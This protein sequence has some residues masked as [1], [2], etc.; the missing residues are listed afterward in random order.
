[1]DALDPA[2]SH[3]VENDE[4]DAG[5]ILEHR[6]MEDGEG[7]GKSRAGAPSSF[8]SRAGSGSRVVGDSEGVL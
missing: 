4:G 8:V 7:A 5:G 6:R 3:P 1:M 2:E